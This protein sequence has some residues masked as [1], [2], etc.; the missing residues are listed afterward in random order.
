MILAL[1]AAIAAAEKYAMVFGG[2]D[3]WGNYSIT[4]D[5]C[6]TYD[7]LIKAGIKPENIIYMTYTTDVTSNRNPFK[8]MIFT[9]PAETTDGDWAKYGCF[10]H[11]DY[12]DKEITPSVFLAILSG[13][14]ET[15]KA[16]TGKE[17][18]K[19]LAAGPDDTVFTYFIDHGAEGIIV[20][21]KDYVT[22][23][24]LLDSLKTAHEKKLYGKWVWF[25]ETCYSESKNLPKDWDINIMTA[26][27]DKPYGWMIN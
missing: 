5:P 8:G 11:V 26:N 3:G 1:I 16:K 6:R 27:D 20:V 19:V 23:E 12:T 7:D 25:M 17:N 18:P 21:G 14:A 15:V 22:D 4:S 13:D 24:Q 9:D 10:E 2:A